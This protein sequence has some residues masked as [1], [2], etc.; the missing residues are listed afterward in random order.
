MSTWYEGMVKLAKFLAQIGA[1]MYTLLIFIIVYSVIMRYF[2]R[3]PDIRT[4]FISCWL[5]GIGF[6]LGLSYTLHVRGHITVDIVFLRLPLRWKYILSIGY[7]LIII[8]YCILLLPTAVT[9]AWISTLHNELD[10]SMV[11]IAPPVWWYRWVLVISLIT[12]LTQ[13]VVELIYAVK[14][15]EKFIEELARPK[16]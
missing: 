16:V 10:S 8:V 12:F 2:L 7:L 1:T 6:L 15:R 13:A 4:F 9:W 14:F 5:M 3:M 11:V